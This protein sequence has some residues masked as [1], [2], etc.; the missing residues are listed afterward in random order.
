[1]GKVKTIV[2]VMTVFATLGWSAN[3]GAAKADQ[4][5]NMTGTLSCAACKLAG[6]SDHKCGK[7]CCQGCIKGGDSVLLE[8]KEGRLYLL[9]SKEKE[10]P[11]ITTEHMDLMGEKVNVTGIMAEKGGIKGI[12]VERMNK[13]AEPASTKIVGAPMD[14]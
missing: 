4:S 9:I 10:K 6:S 1:M 3:I 5:V 13:A 8:D 11:V 7:E 12:Y 14:H 2:V